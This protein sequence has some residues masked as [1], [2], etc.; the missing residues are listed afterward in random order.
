M[1]RE[2]SLTLSQQPTVCARPEPDGYGLRPPTIFHLML[3][4]QTQIIRSS[5]KIYVHLQKELAEFFLEWEV[6]QTKRVENNKT[7][8]LCS[9][10]F[11]RK[12]CRL[13]DN[14]EKY[15]TTRQT[16]DENII[17]SKLFSCRIIKATNTQ[18]EYFILLAFP[19]QQR[20][21]EFA[22]ALR[23]YSYTHCLSLICKGLLRLIRNNSLIRLIIYTVRSKSYRTKAI[24]TKKKKKRRRVSFFLFMYSK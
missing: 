8:F 1:L 24:K 22:S 2:G 16:T 5:M 4:Y 6:F 20:L 15:G 14:V 12:S 23:L 3:S 17:R 10:K 19:R 18:G 7:H 9:I 21:R 13:R 11:S